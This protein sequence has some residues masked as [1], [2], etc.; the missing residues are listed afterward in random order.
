M[1]IFI[2]KIKTPRLIS[3]AA[4][5]DPTTISSYPRRSKHIFTKININEPKPTYNLWIVRVIMINSMTNGFA[6]KT[7]K[8]HKWQKW[9]T[10][11]NEQN[12]TIMALRSSRPT[13][14]MIAT[15][16][17][18][19]ITIVSPTKTNAQEIIAVDQ[20]RVIAPTPKRAVR[21]AQ[22][23]TTPETGHNFTMRKR[24]TTKQTIHNELHAEPHTI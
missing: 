8:T 10:N 13:I 2:T 3:S 16:A 24:S 4:T 14:G 22:V 7:I 21:A 15:S 18:I 11:T 5:A 23:V 6:G 1:G 12:K 19:A 17:E 20:T 9:M